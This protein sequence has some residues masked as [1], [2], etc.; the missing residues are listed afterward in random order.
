M[1]KGI[2][3][4]IFYRTLLIFLGV[5]LIQFLFFNYVFESYYE[6]RRVDETIE[7]IESRTN[8]IETSAASQMDPLITRFAEEKGFY[9]T[10]FL[11]GEEPYF[12]LEDS[13]TFS[14]GG[15]EAVIPPYISKEVYEDAFQVGSN[16][17]RITLVENR[18]GGLYFPLS[19]TI[20]EETFS[21]DESEDSLNIESL[22]DFEGESLTLTSRLITDIDKSNERYATLSQLITGYLLEDKNTESFSETELEGEYFKSEDRFGEYYVFVSPLTV[23]N[24][25]YTMFT[26]MPIEPVEAIIGD[27]ITFLGVSSLITV[28]LLA[29]L[30]FLNAR[31]IALPLKHLNNSV[32]R[33]A[34]L[35]FAPIEEVQGDNEIATLSRNI[36]VMRRNLED[37]M[38]RLNAQ[39]SRLKE[40]LERENTLDKDRKDFIASLSHEMKTPL[41]VIEA[42]SEALRDGVFEKEEDIKE[43]LELI[44]N[45]IQKSK[46]L[47]EGIMD[48]YKVDRPSYL[49]TF[50][51]INLKTVIE[52]A[53][54]E[55][56]T[57]LEKE[58]ITHSLTGKDV[59]VKGDKE[60]LKLAFSNVFSNA[61]KHSEKGAT[62]S[63]TIDTGDRV[64]VAITN[65]KASMN[66]EL[67][68]AFL[69]ETTLSKATEKGSGVG[70]HIIRLIMNQHNAKAWFENGEEKVIFHASFEEV[71]ND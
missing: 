4:S 52:E 71:T 28:V 35:D 56:K 16:V 47:I 32:K 13:D 17:T 44:Q 3:L 2:A 15:Y 40:S 14:M 6:Q 9:V 63:I 23:N 54:G 21:Y 24:E 38:E 22:V 58:N 49:E 64:H 41:S 60:K 1:N 33:I 66:K 20:G 57:L 51:I 36:N 50:T 34:N 31:H 55:S 30:T 10:A 61:A 8:T 29:G 53:L 25:A 45:E 5:L 70:L 18:E 39:N 26:V 59:Y 69:D 11:D 46:S 7:A 27:V 37:S 43:Q 48:T 65:T 19:I 67:I 42:S 62:L 12:D 68:Q